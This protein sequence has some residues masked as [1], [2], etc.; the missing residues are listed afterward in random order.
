MRVALTVFS[1]GSKP[2]PS[3]SRVGASNDFTPKRKSLSEEV[4]T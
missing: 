2:R 4:N 1:V 3:A